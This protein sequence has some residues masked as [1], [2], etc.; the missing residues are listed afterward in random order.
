MIVLDALDECDDF[1]DV[2]LLLP[3]FGNSTKVASVGLRLLVTSRPEIPIR[4]D[5]QDMKHIT[6]HEL[7]L[8]DV[9]RHILDRDIKTFVTY[10]LAQIRDDRGLPNSWPGDD[11][12]QTIAA[13]AGGLFIYAATVCRLSMTVDWLVL[14]LDS[15]RCV[16]NKSKA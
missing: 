7:A 4:L 14:R 15:S 9:P 8:H 3:L 6:Y 16:G 12:A 5:F 1:D 11:K 10:E 13:Q 2:R